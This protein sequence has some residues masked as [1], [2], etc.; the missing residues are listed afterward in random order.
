VPEGDS[1]YRV[2]RRLD[3]LAG[4]LLASSEFRVPRY[5][6]VDL[7][8][9][10]MLATDTHGKHLLTRMEGGLTVHTHL[11]MDGSWT[12]LAP[13]RRLPRRLEPDIRL[14]LV[15]VGGQ[16]AAGLGLPVVE[17][18]PTGREHTVVGHLGPD[19]LRADWDPAEA[20]RRLTARPERPLAAALLDQR[21]IA[22]L[23]NLWA[24]E[25]CFLRG[26]SP[27]TPVGAVDV[28]RVVALAARTLR[29]SAHHPQAAQVTTG[30]TRRGENHW[31]SGRAGRACLR[32][33]TV[34]RAVAEVPGDPDR[35]RTWWCPSCQPGPAPPV[36]AH[37]DC[38]RWQREPH[39]HDR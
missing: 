36:G 22:G 3:R 34:V 28:P 7:S 17:L 20:V 15:T 11:G 16:R 30:S 29:F 26:H 1:V 24:N 33:G 39:V 37:E 18:L 25:L 21:N 10:A 5:A 35:R 32:C 6:T 19:P 4:Q 31:V 12:V 23:G 14:L 27:W 13:G 8:G 9:R 38:D 2:A